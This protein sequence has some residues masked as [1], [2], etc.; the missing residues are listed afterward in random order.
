MRRGW[1]P[2]T[3]SQ[4]RVRPPVA[5]K[6]RKVVVE[7]RGGGGK[8]A[9]AS[10]LRL[11]GSNER[12]TKRSPAFVSQAPKGR[13]NP[14]TSAPRPAQQ[15]HAGL[16][17]RW[18]ACRGGRQGGRDGTHK[19]SQAAPPCHRAPVVVAPWRTG[20]RGQPCRRRPPLTPGWAV[21]HCSPH[22]RT[23]TN[24][25]TSIS[26]AAARRAKTRGSCVG[27]GSATTIGAARR[28]RAA[29][30]WLEGPAE[31]VMVLARRAMDR[32]GML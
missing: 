26:T 9:A 13:R 10:C 5:N 31:A 6:G 14:T 28:C 32:A 23:P 4:V 2:C 24:P 12:K 18:K 8:R 15:G 16:V 17:G 1:L 30:P 29:R 20:C 7:R 19:A 21:M 25:R 11:K 27:A 3:L 22:A